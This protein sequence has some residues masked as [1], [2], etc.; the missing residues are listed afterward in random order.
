MFILELAI[1]EVLDII[2]GG[3]VNLNVILWASLAGCSLSASLSCILFLT[4]LILL[5][6]SMSLLL[7]FDPFLAASLVFLEAL[8]FE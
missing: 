8:H 3:M 5:V 1:V 6:E 2:D 4:L 7:I